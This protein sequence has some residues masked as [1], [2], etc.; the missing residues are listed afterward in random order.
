M[1]MGRTL[2]ARRNAAQLR[3]PGCRAHP[4]AR[5]WRR[6]PTMRA[7]PLRRLCSNAGVRPYPW[8]A[9]DVPT[10]FLDYATAGGVDDAGETVRPRRHDARRNPATVR[11][12][13]ETA[14]AA[15]AERVY[16]TGARPG[17]RWMAT[18]A[19]GWQAGRHHFDSDTPVA[20]FT[21]RDTGARVE[22]R[23]AAEWFGDGTYS[24]RDA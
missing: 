19:E 7:H 4:R 22:I 8:N 24:A 15:G 6:L 5:G 17:S 11:D 9:R 14:R 23:R 20:R 2:R 18:A 12:L 3:R 21:H 13:L 1:R 16:L 10:A